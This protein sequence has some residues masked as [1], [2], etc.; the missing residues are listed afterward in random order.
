MQKT[1]LWL[2]VFYIFIIS[3]VVFSTLLSAQNPPAPMEIEFQPLINF[4]DFFVPLK[5][6][7]TDQLKEYWVMLLSIFFVWFTLMCAL[8]YLEG[9]ME[10]KFAIEHQKIVMQDKQEAACLERDSR[11][12][13]LKNME[14]GTISDMQVIT[15]DAAIGGAAGTVVLNSDSK[16]EVGSWGGEHDDW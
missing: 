6:W 7:F 16:R 12:N 13:E 15:R 11:Q 9:W 10:R 1:I 4:D 8:S 3:L 14:T 2:T 5:Q